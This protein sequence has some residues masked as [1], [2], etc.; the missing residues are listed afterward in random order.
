MNELLCLCRLSGDFFGVP[1]VSARL[2]TRSARR[3]KQDVFAQKHFCPL[4]CERGRHRELRCCCESFTSL[5]YPELVKCTTGSPC[6]CCRK[7]VPS[8]LMPTCRRYRRTTWTRGKVHSPH[9]GF[10]EKKYCSMSSAHA[11]RI[12]PTST[13]RAEL[14]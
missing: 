14:I 5:C 4:L 9:P 3:M 10:V 13:E 7:V 11:G 8:K 6:G 1:K 12:S 2:A